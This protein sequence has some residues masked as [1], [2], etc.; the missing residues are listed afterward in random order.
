MILIHKDLKTE[1]EI[2]EEQ[3]NIWVIESKSLL[4]GFIRELMEQS[5]GE[6]GGFVL[7]EG[8]EVLRLKD[9]IDIISDYFNIS[10]NSKK[11]QSRIL[12]VLTKYAEDD[13]FQSTIDLKGHLQQ[14]IEGLIDMSDMDI[15]YDEN[16]DIAD[17]LKLY[18]IC[19]DDLQGT[20]LETIIRYL[21]LCVKIFEKQC[22]IF[23][24]LSYYMDAEEIKELYKFIQ[25]E[26]IC[27]LFIENTMEEYHKDK[28][29]V[30]LDSDYC[31]I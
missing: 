31:I 16:L 9:H 23:V 17:I 13:L 12:K 19:I 8:K 26:K 21:R 27:A 10:F 6:D 28:N 14:Y 24:N 30:I 1:I 2:T 4:G 20:I 3:I 7:Y 29:C 5:R 11:I 18:S 25:Y 22:Y 15:K